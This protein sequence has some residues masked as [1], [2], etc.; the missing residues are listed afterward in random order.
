MMTTH[1]ASKRGDNVVNNESI[2]N[3]H[4]VDAA[5]KPKRNLT[6][7]FCGLIRGYNDIKIKLTFN[8]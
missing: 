8:P 6:F 1:A 5:R 3:D 7:H 2:N 4:G